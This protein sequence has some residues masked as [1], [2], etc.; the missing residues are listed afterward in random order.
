MGEGERV[1]L[2][3]IAQM[4]KR[5]SGG[6]WTLDRVPFRVAGAEKIGYLHCDTGA[7]RTL[8]TTEFVRR[9]GLTS[10]VQWIPSNARRAEDAVTLPNGTVCGAEGTMDIE[11]IL[12]LQLDVAGD[13]AS[14]PM[15]VSWE[16]RITLGNVWVVNLGDGIVME[17]LPDVYVS[18]ADWGRRTGAQLTPLADLVEMVMAGA[19]VATSPRAPPRSAADVDCVEVRTLAALTSAASANG[20]ATRVAEHPED[21]TDME[22][23][24]AAQSRICPTARDTEVGRNGLADEISQDL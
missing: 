9:A 14:E 10:R 17:G 23:R 2:A 3:A 12:Q 8:V 5:D 15:W 18:F 13:E 7:S 16:R 19:R 21:M 20:G 22:F 1:S 4:A 6:R 11:M 24:A